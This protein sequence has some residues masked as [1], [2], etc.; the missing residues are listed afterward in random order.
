MPMHPKWPK[1]PNAILDPHL[2]NRGIERDLGPEHADTF[3]RD[4]HKD[5]KAEY[6]L[7]NSPFND[8]DWHRRDEDAPWKYGLPRKREGQLR[9]SAT[10]HPRLR[11][12]QNVVAASELR[13]VSCKR[14]GLV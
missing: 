13:V 11:I 12:P 2:A 10:L 8:S 1:S 3:C 14:F 5:L 7:A 9:L 6:V 4:P